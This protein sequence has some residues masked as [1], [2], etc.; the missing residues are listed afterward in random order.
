MPVPLAQAKV[1]SGASRHVAPFGVG[2]A[3][4]M[5][6]G[7]GSGL[8]AAAL[9]LVFELP[10]RLRPQAQDTEPCDAADRPDRLRLPGADV[11]RG[12]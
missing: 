11:S 12:E 10:A 3:A 1:R 9:A 6:A 5:A 2:F 8:Q 4:A 7:I